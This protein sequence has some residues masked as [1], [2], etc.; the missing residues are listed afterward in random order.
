MSWQPWMTTRSWLTTRRKHRN[1]Y[2]PLSMAK[3]LHRDVFK[4]LHN[5]GFAEKRRSMAWL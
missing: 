3:K 2:M 1:P 5:T 4:N